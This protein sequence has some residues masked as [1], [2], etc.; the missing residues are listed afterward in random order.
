MQVALYLVSRAPS[1]IKK[2]RELDIASSPM[3]FCDICHHRNG[4]PSDLIAEP[5][6]S[7]KS[8]VLGDGVNA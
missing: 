8:G 1:E 3:T 6:V 2:V 5:K 4:S 7:R